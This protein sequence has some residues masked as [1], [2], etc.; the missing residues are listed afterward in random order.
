MF[1]IFGL[2]FMINEDFKPYLIEI[3]TNPDI[4]TCTPVC[5]RVIPNMVENAIRYIYLIICNRIG[6]DPLFP[7]PIN[8]PT[9]KKHLKFD[10]MFENNKFEIIFDENVDG[11]DLYKLYEGQKN[12][13]ILF[14][15]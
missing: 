11:P 14:H 7:P 3:N 15:I 4:T 5:A 6:L 9:S 13:S 8:W 12:W 1:E 2:D 10:N